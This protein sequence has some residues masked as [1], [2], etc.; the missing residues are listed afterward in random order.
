[1]N[2]CIVYFRRTERSTNQVSKPLYQEGLTDWMK[3]FPMHLYHNASHYAP[4]MAQLGYD[5]L[6]IPPNYTALKI[7]RKW[8]LTVVDIASNRPSECLRTESIIKIFCLCKE[9]FYCLRKFSN[10]NALYSSPVTEKQFAAIIVCSKWK[11]AECEFLTEPSSE[12]RSVRNGSFRD[13]FGTWSNT[14]W[15]LLYHDAKNTG[16]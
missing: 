16:F 4:L 6:R 8:I 3:D 9:Q 11:S 1:M 10:W 2:F 5:T 13:I 15:L 14:V 12:I 7:K